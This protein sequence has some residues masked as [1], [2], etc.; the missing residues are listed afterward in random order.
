M[1]KADHDHTGDVLLV[2]VSHEG[3][4]GTAHRPSS[5]GD[6]AK[7][8]G[9]AAGERAV[10]FLAR[11]RRRSNIADLQGAAEA[12]QIRR[13]RIRTSLSWYPRFASSRWVSC[14]TE[15]LRSRSRL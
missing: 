8:Q 7:Q 2:A 14:R 10:D 6:D 4:P 11:T 9:D 12:D 13:S 5:L 15:R 1:M 3:R